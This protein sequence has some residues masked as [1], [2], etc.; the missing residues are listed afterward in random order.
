MRENDRKFF[1]PLWRRVGVT[2]FCLAWSGWEWYN[3]QTLWATMV[4]GIFLYCIWAFFIKFDPDEEA[5]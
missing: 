1:K 3:E 2:L 4:G 5:E